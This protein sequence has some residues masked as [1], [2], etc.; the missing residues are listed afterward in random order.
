MQRTVRAV[1][2]LSCVESACMVSALTT[3]NEGASHLCVAEGERA[4]GWLDMELEVPC[5]QPGTRFYALGFR[6]LLELFFRTTIHLGWISFR[7]GHQD[8]ATRQRTGEAPAYWRCACR[9][10]APHHHMPT[11]CPRFDRTQKRSGVEG[12]DERQDRRQK[13]SDGGWVDPASHACPAFEEYYREQ[14]I[15]PPEVRTAPAAAGGSSCSIAC[16]DAALPA[17]LPALPPRRRPP[18]CSSSDDHACGRVQEWGTFMACLRR[19]LPTTFR[20]NG[21]GQHAE[22]LRDKL[23]SDFLSRF[24]G[25]TIDVR[26][27]LACRCCCRCRCR[28]RCRPGNLMGKHKGARAAPQQLQ[29]A[30]T[31]PAPRDATTPTSHH[32]PHHT[33]PHH[34]TT[35]HTP[36]H[37]TTQHTAHHTPHRRTR[38]LC[39][40]LCGPGAAVTTFQVPFWGPSSH[41]PGAISLRFV[42]KGG[43]P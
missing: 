2:G 22:H 10:H 5:C 36:H 23:Q 29:A 34:T 42:A 11:A 20:I 1:K 14:A 37:H 26:P 21:G 8:G 16:A 6:R 41:F 40:P 27:M 18:G 12:G 24:G 35:Q 3:T 30:R 9:T 33:T 28:C 31:A 38:K 39:M 4:A 15:C 32:T 7:Q 25:A 13:T 19:P 17:A 43:G